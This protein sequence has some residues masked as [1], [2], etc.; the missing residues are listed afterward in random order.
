MKPASH[1]PN[2]TTQISR[3]FILLI[4]FTILGRAS[5]L[6]SE[7]SEGNIN[8]IGLNLENSKISFSKSS[9]VLLEKLWRVAIIP[10]W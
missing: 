5:P 8:V 10:F 1:A 6:S 2:K 9:L 7:K 4:S 3:Y